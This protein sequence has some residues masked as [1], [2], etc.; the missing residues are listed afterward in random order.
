[1]KITKEEQINQK[2]RLCSKTSRTQR[3]LRGNISIKGNMKSHLARAH[4]AM[5]AVVAVL[6]EVPSNQKEFV[7]DSSGQRREDLLLPMST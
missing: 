4:R 2:L 5:K 3:K 1:M 7:N 6:P